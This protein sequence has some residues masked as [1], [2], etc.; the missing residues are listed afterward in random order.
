[1]FRDYSCLL[2]ADCAAEPVGQ[3]FTRGNHE[4]SL[5][6]IQVRFGWTAGSG[7]IL[8]ALDQS[9]DPELSR[10]SGRREV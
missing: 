8:R 4:A 7:D 10:P 9:D 2:V 5:L 1:M 6:V 3:E